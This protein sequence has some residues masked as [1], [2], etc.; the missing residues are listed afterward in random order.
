MRT[1]ELTG[2]LSGKADIDPVLDAE[3]LIVRGTD[4]DLAAVAIRLLR[5][6]KLDEIAVA[7]LPSG[8]S[9]IAVRAH[10]ETASSAKAVAMPLIRDDHGGVLLGSGTADVSDA[11]IYCDS[12]QLL[13]GGTARVHVRPSAEGVTVTVRRRWRPARTA[14]GRAV[15]FGCAP[16]QPVADGIPHPR[17]LERWSWY[18]HVSDLWLVAT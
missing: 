1:A 4:A 2:P 14:S 11:T 7:Y 6:E 5:K 12:T 18:R 13:R 9:S 17:H 16:C 3:R 8:E 10:S 15:Q